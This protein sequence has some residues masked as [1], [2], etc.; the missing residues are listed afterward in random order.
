MN[1]V[2]GWSFERT[3]RDIEAAVLKKQK[4]QGTKER[5][6]PLRPSW[7]PPTVSR[8]VTPKVFDDHPEHHTGA[9][10]DQQLLDP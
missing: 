1:T 2:K 8:E 6:V 5:N 9:Q 4:A 7:L 3:T 10:L